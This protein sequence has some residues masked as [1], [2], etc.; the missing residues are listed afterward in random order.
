MKPKFKG[1]SGPWHTSRGEY[2]ELFVDAP[3]GPN[4]T[5][6]CEVL[7]YEKDDM[8]AN[9]RLIAAAPEL[10]EALQS[11]VEMWKVAADKFDWGRSCLDARTIQLLNE[12]PALAQKAI[13]K[14][15]EGK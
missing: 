14:A 5:T 15:L 11:M 10:L 9:A 8:E 7:D 3:I 4:E 12:S 2:G 13:T 1:T 6:I